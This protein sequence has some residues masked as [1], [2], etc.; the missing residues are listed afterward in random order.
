MLK[1][2]IAKEKIGDE[3]RNL[4]AGQ[5]LPPFRAL[6]KKLGFSQVTIE[7]ALT[8][9][10]QEKVIQ[11][12]PGSGIFVSGIERCGLNVGV[13]LPYM[14][15]Q[16]NG[17]MLA[18]IQKALSLH[19]HNLL[20]MSS[21]NIGAV[22]SLYDTIVNNKLAD[23]IVNTSTVDSDNIEYIKFIHQIV[24]SGVRLVMID[25]SIPGIRADYIGHDN[26]TP[27][28]L[29]T[30]RMI[31]EGCHKF[32]IVGQLAA[33][34][35]VARLRG[36]RNAVNGHNIS[37]YQIDSTDA[38]DFATLAA[39]ITASK[40][41]GII[42]CDPRR[43]INI[44]YELKIILGSKLNEIAVVGVVEQNETL[45]ISHAVTLEKQCI[46]IGRQAAEMLLTRSGTPNIKFV[47]L[48]RK[49]ITQ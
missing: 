38:S 3:I 9:L 4:K 20:L 45:P 18:G 19:N 16:A 23:I 25:Y 36:I 33:Y 34:T 30:K 8:E 47:S 31:A 21:N 41:D 13:I 6:I 28:E 17:Q 37:L 24:D 44:C 2:Q 49:L 22:K 39:E 11:R 35:Y 14:D 32:V 42:L 40:P 26:S 48:K 29:E 10:E 1:Y 15:I 12:K 43:N 7:R 46:E 5:P 27:F